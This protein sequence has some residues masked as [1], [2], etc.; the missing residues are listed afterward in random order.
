MQIVGDSIYEKKGRI[1]AV[2]PTNLAKKRNFKRKYDNNKNILKLGA[3][4]ESE[5]KL[6]MLAAKEQGRA[7]NHVT[8]G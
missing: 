5:R 7:K 1:E 6:E 2:N 4:R 8:Q 3:S